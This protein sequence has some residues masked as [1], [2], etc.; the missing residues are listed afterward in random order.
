MTFEG[1]DTKSPSEAVEVLFSQ[2]IPSLPVISMKDISRICKND[3]KY[4]LRSGQRH[5]AG[6][7]EHTWDLLLTSLQKLKRVSDRIIMRGEIG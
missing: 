3:L 1:V 7:A 5:V 6:A 4:D 2:A